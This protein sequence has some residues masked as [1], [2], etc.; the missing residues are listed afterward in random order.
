[1]SGW[2][3]NIPKQGDRDPEFRPFPPYPI[4]SDVIMNFSFYGPASFTRRG[5]TNTHSA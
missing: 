3:E 1:M 5:H 4:I 2:L